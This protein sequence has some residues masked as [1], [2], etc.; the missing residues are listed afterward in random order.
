M[1]MKEAEDP[2]GGRRGGAMEPAVE[3]EVEGLVKVTTSSAR[4]CSGRSGNMVAEAILRMALGQ[5]FGCTKALLD[6]DD[7]S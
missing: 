2:M 3:D 5:G 1:D 4:F 7:S 6:A